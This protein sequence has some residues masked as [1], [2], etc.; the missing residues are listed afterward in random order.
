MFLKGPFKTA[1]KEHGTVDEVIR[2]LWSFICV[3]RPIRGPILFSRRQFRG[4][5][6]PHTERLWKISRLLVVL[7]I[8]Q[9]EE[10]LKRLDGLNIS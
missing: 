6:F 1:I 3:N 4:T 7:L 10:A 2:L 5:M 8:P 9:K